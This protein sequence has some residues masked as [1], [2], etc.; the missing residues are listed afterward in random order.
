MTDNLL[1]KAILIG[2]ALDLV[3]KPSLALRFRNRSCG[4]SSGG[5]QQAVTGRRNCAVTKVMRTSR[6]GENETRTKYR[7]VITRQVSSYQLQFPFPFPDHMGMTRDINCME[8]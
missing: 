7:R 5:R 8:W 4:I 3:L 2:K 1:L 6:G